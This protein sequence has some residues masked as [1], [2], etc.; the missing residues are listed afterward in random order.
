MSVPSTG[1]IPSASSASP[2]IPLPA[3]MSIARHSPAD[4]PGRSMAAPS[5]D[6]I[7]AGETHRSRSCTIR[8]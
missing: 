1:R 8:S 7:T 5:N 4:G 2:E 6:A 3:A